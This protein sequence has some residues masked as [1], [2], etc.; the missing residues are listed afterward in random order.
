M[1]SRKMPRPL[2]Y[3]WDSVKAI[4]RPDGKPPCRW[5]KGP[6]ERPRRNWC[7]NP[8][9]VHEWKRR[10]SWGL[11]RADVFKRDGGV[12]SGCG[13]DTKTLDPRVILAAITA[14]R[15][16]EPEA[17]GRRMLLYRNLESAYAWGRIHKCE[18]P[19]QA[20]HVIPVVEGGDWFAMSN[21]RTLCVP[22]HRR[23]TAALAGRRKR[24]RRA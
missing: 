6:V 20:D 17:I 24:K 2:G 22:C 9:C 21:L 18:S 15:E 7:G 5:C 10:T 12:C 14:S 11:T 1:A 4:V 16:S 13:L 19:W 23:E 3:H 8:V